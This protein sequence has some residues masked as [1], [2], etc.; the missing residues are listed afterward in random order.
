MVG[1]LGAGPALLVGEIFVNVPFGFH[2]IHII[3]VNDTALV[4]L[5][6][7]LYVRN[8]LDEF[9]LVSQT[10]LFVTMS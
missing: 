7:I 10:S 1:S 6:G 8:C 4:Y 5:L 9:P 3:S 2:T